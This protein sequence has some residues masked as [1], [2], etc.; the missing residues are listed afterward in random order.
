M[1]REQ[2]SVIMI[3]AA[4]WFLALVVLALP[5]HTTPVCQER[6]EEGGRSYALLGTAGYACHGN[7]AYTLAEESIAG[8]SQPSGCIGELCLLVTEERVS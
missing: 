3:M 8:S 6:R 4:D 1:D 5:C 7:C 2:H